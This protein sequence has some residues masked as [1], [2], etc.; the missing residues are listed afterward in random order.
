MSTGSSLGG[1]GTV[2]LLFFFCD[3]DANRLMIVERR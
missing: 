2:P 3:R 1:D